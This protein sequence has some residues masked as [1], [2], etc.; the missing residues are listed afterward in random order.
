[1]N[2]FWLRLTAVK[3]LAWEVAVV[4]LAINI[5]GLAS[6]LY[7]IQVLNRYLALGIDG[8]LLTLTL[9]ALLALAL[10]MLARSARMDVMQWLCAKADKLLAEAAFTAITHS[11]FAAVESLPQALRREALGGLAVVQQSFG[12]QNLATLVDGPFGLLFLLVMFLLSPTLALVTLLLIL[13]VAVLTYAIY[14]ISAAPTRDLTRAG[15]AWSSQQGGLASHTE[16]VRAFPVRDMLAG[17]WQESLGDMKGLRRQMLSIQSFSGNMGYAATM[18]LTIL[19]YAVG[20]REVF[21]GRLDVG[22]LIG[23]NILAARAMSAVTRVLQ[24]VDPVMRGERSLEM[25]GQVARLPMERGEGMPL[26]AWSG[27]MAFEDMAFAHQRQPTP[28]FE[29]LRLDV[30]TSSVIA[31]TGAN[32]TGK[33]TFARLLVGMLEPTRGRILVD[34]MDL[35]QALPAWWRRQLVYLPQ[36]PAF[37]DGTLRENL[38]LGDPAVTDE[39]LINLCREVGLG[40]YVEG[41][42]DGL[43]MPVINAGN[44]IPLGIRRRLALVRALAVNGPLVVLDDPMDGVDASGCQAIA[45]VLNRLVRE[46]KTIFVMSNEPFIIKA[47]QVVIDLNSKPV[48]RIVIAAE[49]RDRQGEGGGA[50]AT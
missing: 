12:P 48:P 3:R 6:S 9:G 30:P 1:M 50:D 45:A 24:M 18:L 15:L 13:M 47:A 27:R 4:S 36:E 38:S 10:E 20:S 8:T 39:Q 29:S 32:G 22:T 37:F 19:V 21:A 42:Q 5:L 25:L 43:L 49:T 46:G 31:I 11:S 17:K 40:G 26:A 41:S 28:L 44:S 23:V 7:S 14:I 33:T 16:L 35:R 2:E 34:G